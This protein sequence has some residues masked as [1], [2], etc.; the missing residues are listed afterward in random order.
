MKPATSRDLV[1]VVLAAC[2]VFGCS[3]GGAVAPTDA[4]ATREFA[5]IDVE[6]SDGGDAAS[7]A[8]DLGVEDVDRTPPDRLD[9]AADA[10]SPRDVPA[11]EAD[12]PDACAVSCALA[13]ARSTC[14]AGACSLVE[15]EAGWGDC[16]D[17]AEDGCESDLLNARDSCGACGRVCVAGSACMN[18][19]CGHCCDAP[20]FGDC[21]GDCAN[22][23]EVDLRS[24]AEHCGACGL[25]CPTATP[26]CVDGRCM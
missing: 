13:H 17:R 12:A 24:S 11:F 14:V 23:C 8:N 7:A 9:P 6:I 16:N 22:G 4:G 5:P 1:W 18:G 25:V 19:S 20:G 21:D 15:C 26:R 2:C 10:S 3:A